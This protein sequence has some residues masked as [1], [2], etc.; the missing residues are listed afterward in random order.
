MHKRLLLASLILFLIGFVLIW[1]SNVGSSSSVDLAD[2]VGFALLDL[3][4]LGLWFVALIMFVLGLVM[5][6]HKE[7]KIQIQPFQD[8]PAKFCQYCGT[9]NNVDA[10]FCQKCGK[11]L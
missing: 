1:A 8:G 2:A 10:V 11:S 3:G 6:G 7:Q 5:K 4:G 9:R